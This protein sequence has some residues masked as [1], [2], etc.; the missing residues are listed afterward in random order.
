MNL[1]GDMACA[2]CRRP[3]V[4]DPI[5]HRYDGMWLCPRCFG[6]DVRPAFR[7]ARRRNRRTQ[8]MTMRPC[9]G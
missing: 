3:F 6:D 5:W 9:L 8:P 2:V 4:N 1:D 7:V